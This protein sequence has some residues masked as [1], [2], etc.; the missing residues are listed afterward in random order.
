MGGFMFNRIPLIRQLKWRETITVKAVWGS[1]DSKNVPSKENG[2]L[3][4][5]KDADGNPYTHSLEKAPYVEV[6]FGV[7]NIFK[8]LHIDYVRR[9]NYLNLPNVD[10]WG[11]RAR[12]AVTF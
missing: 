5:A 6:A 11:I 4:F 7:S 1:L 12:I 9:L 10:K 3:Q 8:L 2:L